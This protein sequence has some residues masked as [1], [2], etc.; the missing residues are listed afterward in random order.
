MLK[1]DKIEKIFLFRLN[2]HITEPFDFLTLSNLNLYAHHMFKQ[3]PV[4][5]WKKLVEYLSKQ[6]NSDGHIVAGY[7]YD[8][9]NENDYR[10][11]Y[12]QKVRDKVF[13][14]DSYDYHYFT[15]MNDLC[16]GKTSNH[17][18]GILVYTKK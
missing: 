1:L 8:I 17:H 13:L 7:F 2:D 4:Q 18:D 5:N 12:H 9:E 15:K 6:L 14:G 11:I 16:C 3:E 10:E